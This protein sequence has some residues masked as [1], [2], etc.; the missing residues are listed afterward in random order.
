MTTPTDQPMTAS[1][2]AVTINTSGGAMID[3]M[4]TAARDV[5]GRDQ[6]NITIQQTVVMTPAPPLPPSDLHLLNFGRPL[7]EYQRNQIEQ[8]LG[9]RISRIIIRPVEFPEDQDFGPQVVTLLDDI[10]FTAH[11]WQ[12]IPLLVNP[13]GFAP[14]PGSDPLASGPSGNN[15]SLYRRRNHQLTSVA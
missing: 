13:P 5:I 9:F 1:A 4:V 2:R 12:T 11:E 10:G 14:A 6:I 3:G 8:A 15:A 7:S